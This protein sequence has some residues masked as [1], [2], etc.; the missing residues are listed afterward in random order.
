MKKTLA[1]LLSLSLVLSIATAAFA[2]ESKS[3]LVEQIKSESVKIL[4][5]D[6]YC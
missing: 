1:S 5:T 4:G 2:Q 3:S 6:P